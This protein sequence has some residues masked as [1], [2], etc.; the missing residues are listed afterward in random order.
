[1][2]VAVG[3][4]TWES[5]RLAVEYEEL[6]PAT[7]KGKAQPVRVFAAARALALGRRPRRTHAGPYVGREAEIGWLR[8][9]FDGVD[10]GAGGQFVAI[11]GEAGMGKSRIV[12]ELRRRSGP[13]GRRT[14]GRAAACRTARASRSGRSARS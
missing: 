4:A 11:V 7:L 5:T 6:P 13:A 9:A 8:E 12:A 1:M 14:G 10:A 3:L 2:G